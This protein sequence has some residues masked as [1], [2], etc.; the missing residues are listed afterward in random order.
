TPFNLMVDFVVA[1]NGAIGLH[2]HD[3]K[4][5]IYYL[6]EGEI[7]MTVVTASGDHHSFDLYPGDAHLIRLGQAHYGVAGPQGARMIAVCVRPA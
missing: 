4:E 3:D 2:R 1:P 7:R 5:E 6:L